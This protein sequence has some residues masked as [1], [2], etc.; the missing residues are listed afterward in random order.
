MGNLTQICLINLQIL[1]THQFLDLTSSYSYHCKKII[2]Y[3]HDLRLNSICL[4]ICSDKEKS[5]KRCSD[6]EKWLMERGYN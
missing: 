1:D 5:N 3:C 4:D 6:L 2:P